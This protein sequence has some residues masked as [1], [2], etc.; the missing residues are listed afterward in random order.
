M[1]THTHTHTP[2]ETKL[3]S[4]N[5]LYPV[6]IGRNE[7]GYIQSIIRYGNRNNEIYKRILDT[8]IYKIESNQIY[9]FNVSKFKSSKILRPKRIG[10]AWFIYNYNCLC[11]SEFIEVNITCVVVLI[12]TMVLNLKPEIYH[13]VT[14]V[15]EIILYQEIVFCNE[16][17]CYIG[18]ST[19]LTITRDAIC[20]TWQMQF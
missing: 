17:V 16:N 18:T 2:I 3:L 9:K 20:W 1:H 4:T 11:L 12:C 8:Y 7:T 6:I 19:N 10:I 13:S 5:R 14:A 15:G